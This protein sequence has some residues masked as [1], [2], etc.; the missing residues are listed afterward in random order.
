MGITFGSNIAALTATRRLAENTATLGDSFERLSSGLRINRAS[1]D[2]AGLAVSSGINLDKKVLT[3]ALRNANDAVS[4]LS[5]AEGAVGELS[6]ILVR[7][8][9]LATQSA[10]GSLSL[11]QRTALDEEAYSLTEEYNRI[12][13]STEFNDRSLL[14]ANGVEVGIQLGFGTESSIGVTTGAELERAVGLGTFSPAGNFGLDDGSGGI[15]VGDFNEDGQIDIAITDD[16]SIYIFTNNNGIFSETASLTANMGIS[17]GIA[18]GDFDNDG[19]LDLLAYEDPTE[20]VQLFVGA[21]DGTFVNGDESATGG[22]ITRFNGTADFNGDGFD[23][24]LAA[25]SGVGSDVDIGFSNGD[26][27]FTFTD[28]LTL[29]TNG[30]SQAIGD[31]NGDGYMDI[32]ASSNATMTSTS[33]LIN[34]GHG[35]FTETTLNVVSKGGIITTGDYN[36]D[37]YDDIS[38]ISG[39]G[40]Q[41]TLLS[42]GDGTFNILTSQAGY[43]AASAVSVDIDGDGIIDLLTANSGGSIFVSIGNGDGTFQTISSVAIGSPGDLAAADLDGDGAV[44]IAVGAPIAATSIYIADTEQSNTL[45][46]LNLLSQQHALEA[47]SVIDD[48]MTRV[49]AENGEIGALVS[50]LSS[51]VNNLS[52]SRDNLADAE[53]RIVDVDVAQESAELVRAQ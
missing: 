33:V 26:G 5:I 30:E 27:T 47:M 14:A 34:D 7:L 44:D 36:H 18:V 3:K 37:G 15:V 6:N 43:G 16:A 39:G 20:T 19:H 40:I 41:R 35:N 21:G 42:N 31:F 10:N 38:A 2:A 23:D 24:V 28:D 9:E 49:A 13:A 46:R 52:I 22:E 4:M 50:R 1:D 45:P 32:V 11:A 17:T 29:A 51:A 12:T 53:S 25:I 8:R 48:A